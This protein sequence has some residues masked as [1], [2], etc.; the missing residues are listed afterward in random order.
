MINM[1]IFIFLMALILPTAIMIVA[2]L[3]FLHCF[4]EHN[5]V[6]Y[7]TAYSNIAKNNQ[8]IRKR[9]VS[10]DITKKEKKSIDALISGEIR[11]HIL[12]NKSKPYDVEN[13]VKNM[14]KFS[15]QPIYK[16]LLKL[17]GGFK[18]E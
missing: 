7:N 15:Q 12:P 18:I 1:S 13:W 16:Q 4:S 17:E 8:Y 5:N 10:K 11:C 6:K 9:Q 2:F 14:S 3:R